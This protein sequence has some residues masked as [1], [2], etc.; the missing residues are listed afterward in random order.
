MKI[1]F[2]PILT[3]PMGHHTV[4]DVLI[5]SITKRRRDLECK[6][7]DLFS[8]KS[9]RLEAFI[10]SGYLRWIRR[11][12]QSY[13]KIYLKTMHDTKRGKN[14]GVLKLFVSSMKRLLEEESPDLIV[15][16]SS[17][18]SHILELLKNTGVQ[19]PPIVN[20]Y[21]DFWMNNLWDLNYAQ[22]HL[23]PDPTFKR[24]LMEH[25]PQED[26][27]VY[28]TGIPV[29]E[30]YLEPKKAGELS[31]EILVSG[32]SMGLVSA[33][34]VVQRIES[35]SDHGYS[36]T[37]LCGRNK[38]LYENI[39]HSNKNVEPIPYI[40]SSEAMNALYERCAAI[41]TKP[42]GVTMSE[43]LHKRLPAFIHGELPGQEEINRN[44]LM[45][46][47]L[48]MSLDW[49][50]SFVEQLDAFFMNRQEQEEWRKRVDAYLSEIQ[51]DPWD[52]LL[53]IIGEVEKK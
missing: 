46:R 11:S 17:I 34:K 52:A 22:Y 29:D 33:K 8:Y 24:F 18:P 10:R 30:C 19:T 35:M 20:V 5:R 44:Y 42:G 50:T 25:L 38:K 49:D 39:S 21:T 40:H 45:K 3:I 31:Q 16:T 2:L 36:V 47:G 15:C 27:R 26:A 51:V 32:G 1:L 7:V 37:A 6:K 48:I 13:G 53:D 9:P 41:I 23:V 4:A 43:C 28:V 12:P 14:Y